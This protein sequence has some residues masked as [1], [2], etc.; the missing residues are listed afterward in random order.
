MPTDKIVEAA[1]SINKAAFS[2]LADKSF[3]PVIPNYLNHAKI[4]SDCSWVDAIITGDA[5]FEVSETSVFYLS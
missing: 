3:F 4:A 5:V 2:P 1:S